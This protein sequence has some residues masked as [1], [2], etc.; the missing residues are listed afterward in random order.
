MSQHPQLKDRRSRPERPAVPK[1]RR[2]IDRHITIPACDDDTVV[3]YATQNGLEYSPALA[4]IIH[5]NGK[6]M[7]AAVNRLRETLRALEARSD[8]AVAKAGRGEVDFRLQKEIQG[9]AK[10]ALD[11]IGG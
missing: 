11:G 2:A 6:L 4:R 8:I 7:G 10:M 9:L 1:A 3:D 5:F